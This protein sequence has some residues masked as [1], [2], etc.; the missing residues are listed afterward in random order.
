MV[1]TYKHLLLTKAYE[2]KFSYCTYIHLLAIFHCYFAVQ[3]IP[4]HRLYSGGGH[5]GARGDRK[6]AGVAHLSVRV[7][8]TRWSECCFL[9]TC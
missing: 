4:G 2:D 3:N 9:N 7:H 8:H 6:R 5:P 1:H